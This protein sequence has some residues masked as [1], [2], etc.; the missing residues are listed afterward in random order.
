MALIKVRNNGTNI[1]FVDSLGLILRPSTDRNNEFCLVDEV[2]A[3]NDPEFMK[4]KILG[5]IETCPLNKEF[6]KRKAVQ[7]EQKEEPEVVKKQTKKSSKKEAVEEKVGTEI[8]EFIEPPE[9]KNSDPVVVVPGEKGKTK[10]SR[11]KSYKMADMPMPK[12]IK[13]SEIRDMKGED[14]DAESQGER[15]IDLSKLDDK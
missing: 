7:E 11:V 9:P 1:L 4:C 10:T 2:Q 6:K 3:E 15:D 12:F 13:E 8:E 14:I 5:S